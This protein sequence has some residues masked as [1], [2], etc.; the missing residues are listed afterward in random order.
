MNSPYNVN[1]TSVTSIQLDHKVHLHSLILAF[2]V[3]TCSFLI[4]F[5]TG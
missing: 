2:G 4:R 5:R 1:S 3:N